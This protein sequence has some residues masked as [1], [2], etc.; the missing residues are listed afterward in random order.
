MTNIV[1]TEH[2]AALS[3]PRPARVVAQAVDR[4]G[5]APYVE[6]AQVTAISPPPRTPRSSTT[7]SRTPRPPRLQLQL[8][9]MV[10]RRHNSP[11]QVSAASSSQLTTRWTGS[12]IG[13]RKRDYLQGRFGRWVNLSRIRP[14]KDCCR[15][16]AP[17]A[18]LSSMRGADASAGTIKSG[19]A[20]RRAAKMVVLDVDHP[21]IESSSRRRRAKKTRSVS[22]A[23]PGPRW[24]SAASTSPAS[25]T[26]TP[27]TRSE[28]PTSSCAPSRRAASSAGSHADRRADRDRRRQGPVP[29]DGAGRLGMRRPRNPVRRHDQRLAHLPGNRT[30]HRQ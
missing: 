25:S 4:P 29:Q 6:A 8:A 16:V 1:T 12:S 23:T 5:R 11:Q 10:Q 30:D 28:S 24:T 27:T 22:C 3:A 20:T 19:G 9:G 7:S 21:D 17:R 15:R 13:T 14:S 18:A 2:F 26:R